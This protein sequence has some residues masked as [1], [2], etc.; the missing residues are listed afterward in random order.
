M[1]IWKIFKSHVCTK[2]ICSWV[3]IDALDQNHEWY[4]AD[5]WSTSGLTLNWHY[6]Q[7]AKSHLTLLTLNRPSTE[8]SIEGQ[9]TLNSRWLSYTFSK[10]N[11]RDT[12]KWIMQF[13]ATLY[14][15]A[16]CPAAWLFR[17]IG[18]SWWK[19]NRKNRKHE[20]QCYFHEQSTSF[21][22][23]SAISICHNSDILF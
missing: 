1:V 5:T 12:V 20:N 2:G 3:A 11:N 18:N 9:L 4:S 10:W 21:Y 14:Q 8:M 7:L 22:S 6:Q 16:G 19:K 13:S 23:P 15:G 17:K